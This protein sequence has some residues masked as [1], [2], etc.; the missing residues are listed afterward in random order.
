[1]LS[2]YLIIFAVVFH[3]T[4]DTVKVISCFTWLTFFASMLCDV[5]VNY[6]TNII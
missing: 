1:M 3:Y 2:L 4:N 6:L 5:R